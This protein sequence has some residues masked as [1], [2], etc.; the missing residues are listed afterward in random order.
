MACIGIVR[1]NELETGREALYPLRMT[2]HSPFRYVKT[3]P[4]IIHLAV[5]LPP[6]LV[7][8]TRYFRHA[9]ARLR[10]AANMFALAWGYAAVCVLRP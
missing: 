9:P 6:P 3:S 7:D 1:Q 8:H 2:K 5:I 10:I 4:E